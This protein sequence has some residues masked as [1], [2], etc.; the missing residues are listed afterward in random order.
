MTG[1][2]RP[3]RRAGLGLEAI[4]DVA[5]LGEDL[6]GV[7]AASAGEGHDDRPSGSAATACSMRASE[8]GDL[9]DEGVE[10]GGERADEFALGLAS[11]SPARPRGRRAAGEQLGRRAAA[12]VG[13]L[14]EEGLEALLAEAGGALGGRIALQEGE[15]D[16]RVDVGE[17][18]SGAGPKALEQGRSWLARARR[19][20][21]RSSRPRT[22]ARSA[23]ISSDRAAAAEAVAVGAQ[24][25]GQQVGVAAIALAA[26]GAVARP[27]SLD[28][29]RMN[30]HHRVT[31]G[32]Q[33][34]DEQAA[35]RSIAIGSSA[36]APALP[37]GRAAPQR[38]RRRGAR[39]TCDDAAGD[40][41]NADAMLAGAP[42][43]SPLSHLSPS[44]SSGYTALAG[45]V[46]GLLI[47]W[48]SGWQDL[49]LH[50]VVRRNLPAPSARRVSCG[51]SSS[52]R[53]WP[54]RKALGWAHATP[55]RGSAPAH[56]K[57]PQ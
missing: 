27:G 39:A 33:R 46:C 41:D 30:R 44:T 52:K 26:G 29:V 20:A 50:P 9:G 4:A 49:A 36:G 22:R 57:V 1:R 23:L 2:R 5:E 48:R 16:R 25:V 17:D 18:G 7:D 55:L 14:G 28:D 3:R 54:S 42:I 13:V 24:Q 8:L 40:V 38:R 6:G 35:G 32:D 19:S 51:L 43:Q 56:P 31:G 47:D 11:P 12:A 53:R 37:G 21:T 45:R 15:R 34:V 10:H